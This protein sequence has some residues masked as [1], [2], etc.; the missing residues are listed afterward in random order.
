MSINDDD[1]YAEL[2][3]KLPRGAS[4]GSSWRD[5]AAELNTLGDTLGQVLRT[6]WQR[7]EGDTLLSSLRESLN[8]I[9][10][11]VNRTDADSPES[12]RA[13]NEL[14]HLIESLRTAA[15]QATD[16]VRPELVTLL[17][18]ANAQLR[19]LGQLDD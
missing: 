7:S 11:D 8:A 12:Q 4:S 13:R 3:K 15:T 2:F 14:S 10:D 17:R 18:E 19:R 9:V 5:V 16:D 1:E 6:A